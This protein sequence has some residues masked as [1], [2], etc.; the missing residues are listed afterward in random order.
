MKSNYYLLYRATFEVNGFT[1]TVHIV[2][3]SIQ[4]SFY[5]MY[6]LH[7]LVERHLPIQQGKK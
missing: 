6:A 4:N 2:Y 5:E 1:L 3:L 7:L